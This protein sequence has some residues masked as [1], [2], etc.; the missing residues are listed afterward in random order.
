MMLMKHD[1]CQEE[2]PEWC[3]ILQ[4]M[5]VVLAPA[6]GISSL[7]MSIFCMVIIYVVEMARC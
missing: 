7:S 3:T 5:A 4:E 6:L 2:Q 1:D